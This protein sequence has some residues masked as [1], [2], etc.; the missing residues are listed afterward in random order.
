MEKIDL[1][2]IVIFLSMLE[3][4]NIQ[5]NEDSEVTL[6]SMLQQVYKKISVILGQS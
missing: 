6:A 5:A 2:K 4:T 3:L 1:L